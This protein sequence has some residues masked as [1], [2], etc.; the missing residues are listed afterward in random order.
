MERV[1]SLLEVVLASD[2]KNSI[3]FPS[4]HPTELTYA[5]RDGLNKA[6]ESKDVEDNKYGVIKSQYRIRTKQGKVIFEPKTPLEFG[7]PIVEL[8]E[9]QSNQ[10][11][12]NIPVVATVLE[13][14]GA[15]IKHKGKR[16]VFPDA[17]A[18]SLR[19]DLERWTDKNNYVITSE[20]PLTLIRNEQ[21]TT[22]QD[23]SV[24]E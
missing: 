21:D 13:I 12:I 23:G 15:L 17:H 8:A 18:L 14:V 22:A 20:F 19:S 9:A 10:E 1:R 16:M 4:P 5:I 2:G 11:E 6:I 7:N 3:G 24:I